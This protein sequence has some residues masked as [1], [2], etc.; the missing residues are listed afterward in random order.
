MFIQVIFKTISLSS[1]IYYFRYVLILVILIFRCFAKIANGNK[2]EYYKKFNGSIKPSNKYP[3]TKN[4]FYNKYLCL[5][6]Q[7]HTVESVVEKPL[8]RILGNTLI[9]LE[10]SGK[11][12]NLEGATKT[13]LLNNA[14]L[15]YLFK[16]TSG[17]Q[18]CTLHLIN[19]SYKSSF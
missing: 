15:Y 7:K 16:V 4:I 9:D 8:E 19:C 3:T 18:N 14:Y 11:I 2:T 5:I 1:S 13:T 10:R 12:E 6:C 17:I